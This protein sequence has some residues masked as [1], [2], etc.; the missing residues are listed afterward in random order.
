MEITIIDEAANVNIEDIEP[1]EGVRRYFRLYFPSK[2]R[3]NVCDLLKEIERQREEINK[4]ER[5]MDTLD[6]MHDALK[7]CTNDLRRNL[8]RLKEIA[9]IIAS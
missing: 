9:S 4:I 6:P 8:D 2:G 5:D 7:K 3:R 1:I